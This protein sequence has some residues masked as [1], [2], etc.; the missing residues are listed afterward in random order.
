M[1][2][3]ALTKQKEVQS[4]ILERLGALPKSR[5]SFS[6]IDRTINFYGEVYLGNGTVMRSI[7][8]N[9]GG[10]IRNSGGPMNLVG[11]VG[12]SIHSGNSVTRGVR[13]YATRAYQSFP[14]L[15]PLRRALNLPLFKLFR[16]RR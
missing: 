14:G 10:T 11:N 6:L 13:G 2:E 7:I 12:G 5:P 1:L 15:Q 4:R 3:E 9:K 16:G 8:N